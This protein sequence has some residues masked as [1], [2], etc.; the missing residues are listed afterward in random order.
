MP[1]VS[2]Q[3]I[4]IIQI[5]EMHPAIVTYHNPTNGG[6]PLEDANLIM[7]ENSL[8]ESSRSTYA[9]VAQHANHKRG[10]RFLPNK[11]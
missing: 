1:P 5:N 8:Q 3:Q 9:K 2:I 4:N 7:K 6:F 10:G 11:T